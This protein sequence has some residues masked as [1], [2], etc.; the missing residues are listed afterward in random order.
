[1][2]LLA[3]IDTSSY[4]AW[5]TDFDAHS[6]DRAQSG[7]TLLQMWHDADAPARV[8]ALF[9]VADRARAD[10]WVKRQSTL[11]G[12]ITARFLRTV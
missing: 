8:M 5:K 4:D 11:H 2:H 9:E 12:G 6:E 7:L 1:M 10:G 3:T